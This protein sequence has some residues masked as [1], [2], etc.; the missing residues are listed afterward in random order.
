MAIAA[1]CGSAQSKNLLGETI[2]KSHT[3][4]LY[5]ELNNTVYNAFYNSP[6]IMTQTPSFTM[7]KIDIDKNGKVSSINF[8]DSADSSLINAWQNRR[9]NRDY[10]ATLEK[11]ALSKYYKDI[12]LLIPLAFEPNAPNSKA[13]FTYKQIEAV[14]KFNQQEFIGPSIILPPIFIP[15]LADHNF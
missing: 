1:K 9:K 14:F 13:H 5:T 8:S 4:S 3:D 12:S 2:R 10:K 11:Y 7:L 6:Y 15:V